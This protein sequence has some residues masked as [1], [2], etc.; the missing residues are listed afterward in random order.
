MF[1]SQFG[2]DPID[3]DNVAIE[4]QVYSRKFSNNKSY[5]RICLLTLLCNKILPTTDLKFK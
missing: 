3:Y 5:L 2:L 4:K 1:C